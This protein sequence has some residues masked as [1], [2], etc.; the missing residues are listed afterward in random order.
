M[1]E[2]DVVVGTPLTQQPFELVEHAGRTIRVET[3]AEI[4]AKKFWYRGHRPKARDLFDLCA[5][6]EADPDAIERIS[7]FIAKHGAAFLR[8]M[9]ERSS[10]M[11]KDFN[12]IDALGLRQSFEDCAERARRIIHLALK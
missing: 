3:N 12:A 9:D 6:A 2:I 4:I 5:V 8:L 11:R 7:P 1:G 10:I